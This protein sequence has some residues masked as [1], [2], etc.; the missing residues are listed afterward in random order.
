MLLD[1]VGRDEA[2]ALS[3]AGRWVVE[4]VVD[5]EAV[6]VLGFELIEF[7][8]EQDV[9]GRHVGV[10]ERDGGEIEWILESRTDDL[11]LEVWKMTMG[12]M[13]RQEAQETRRVRE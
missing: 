5:L 13:Q 6:R 3:P 8:L 12:W 9:L 11:L 7:C 2:Y 4:D 10:D 1:H